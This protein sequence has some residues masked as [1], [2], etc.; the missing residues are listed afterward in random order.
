MKASHTNENTGNTQFRDTNIF[1]SNRRECIYYLFQGEEYKT[2]DIYHNICRHYYDIL[3]ITKCTS[4]Y[5]Q[6]PMCE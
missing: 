6:I 3:F 2:P 5:I 1:Y 4:T